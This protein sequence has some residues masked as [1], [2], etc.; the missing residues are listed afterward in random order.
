MKK[1]LLVVILFS[2]SLTNHIFAQVPTGGTII[3]PA[4]VCSNVLGSYKV[5][6]VVGA[7]EYIWVITGV[8]S[9]S[10]SSISTTERSII[11]G[12]S[13][14]T[15]TVTPKNASGSGTPLT[16]NTAINGLPSKPTITQTGNVLAVPSG[17][18]SYQW[19]FNNSAISGATT[20]TYT[21]TAT[22][23]Y[24]VEITNSTGCSIKSEKRNY[25][26]TAVKE[27]AQ[28]SS[29]TFYPN[30]I[31]NSKITTNFSEKYDLQFFTLDGKIILDNKA[32]KGEVVTELSGI[33]PG[34]YLMKII[35]NNKVANRKII[36]K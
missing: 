5:S 35:S 3:G 20:R 7:T 25:F 9:S 16:F 15:V 4:R 24:D 17:A 14:V 2:L 18:S 6:G 32:L 8:E 19:Y 31:T 34:I 1:I 22:G 29:F 36:V 30:P 10:V 13:N 27:D 12:S 21:L 28:F 26:P 11:F 23:I 33:N